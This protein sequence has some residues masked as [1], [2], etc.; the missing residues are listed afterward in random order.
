MRRHVAGERGWFVKPGSCFF[1]LSR[2]DLLTLHAPPQTYHP[3]KSSR[4]YILAQVLEIRGEQITVLTEQGRI[5]GETRACPP[6]PPARDVE[7][8]SP[9]E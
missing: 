5:N 3:R 8:L 4:S 6:L 1:F 2:C 9:Q 7:E